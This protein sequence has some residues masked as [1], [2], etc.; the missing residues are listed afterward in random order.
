PR[1]GEDLAAAGQRL[2][3]LR[4]D[5][6]VVRRR[7]RTDVG[8]RD[9]QVPGDELRVLVTALAGDLGDRV[10]LVLVEVGVVDR[11]DDARGVQERRPPDVRREAEDV[12]RVVDRVAVGV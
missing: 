8:R 9:E 5:L 4:G 2:D 7:A 6:L 1:P 12:A 10:G 3:A 11:G